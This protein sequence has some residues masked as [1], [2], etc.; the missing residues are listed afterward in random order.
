M[1]FMRFRPQLIFSLARSVPKPRTPPAATLAAATAARRRHHTTAIVTSM[2]APSEDS[3]RRALAER[4]AAV[5]AQA[6]A[7]RAL[8]AGGG[9]SKADVDAAVEAL[10]GLKIEAGAAARRLQQAV[11][12]GTDGAAREELRQAVVNTLERKLFYIPSF[13]IYRGVAG[14]YDYG[15]PG[16][17]VKANVLSFWRQVMITICLEMC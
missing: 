5:D 4:Q 13:K 6:E 10:K 11:G 1:V 14:L 3:L 2:A 7:V 9:A 12:A 15:P 8:K 16:C 17:R